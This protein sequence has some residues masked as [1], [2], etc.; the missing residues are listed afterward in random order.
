M[1]AIGARLQAARER[2]NLSLVQVAERLHVDPQVIHALETEQFG[3][4]GAPV[5]VR[6]HLRH[7]A[8]LV[9]ESA[10]ELLALY[11][12]SA[13]TGPP[14]DLTRMPHAKQSSPLRGVLVV[15]GLALVIGVGLVGSI[16]WIYLDLHPAAAA[17]AAAAAA[18]AIA[19]APAADV[20]VTA[21][22]DAMPAAPVA[23]A[24]APRVPRVPPTTRTAH[25]V[26]AAVAEASV[27]LK[28]NSACWTEV[29]DGQGR[30]LYHAIG[31]A[32]DAARLR[33]A[34]PLKVIV[35]NF[36]VV[37]IEIN[38][39]AQVIPAAAQ[40]GRTAEFLVTQ[41]GGLQPAQTVTTAGNKP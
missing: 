36:A 26:H 11:A 3:E 9:R 39:A 31:A 35:G 19:S 7:Y 18:V 34:A 33:G 23:S 2:A 32:G 10:P 4:L 30:Q 24:P 28:F 15:T 17:A 40:T 37:G 16:H 6:G 8:E 27:T 1:N 29:Y 22:S 14:P 20:P 38:G 25:P 41:D 12:D 13:L 5:Y 21:P